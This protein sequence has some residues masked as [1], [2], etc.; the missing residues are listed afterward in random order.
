MLKDEKQN[1]KLLSLV[2][3]W[4]W[5]HQLHYKKWHYW[6]CSSFDMKI[7]FNPIVKPSE[8]GP[9]VEMWFQHTF[10]PHLRPPTSNTFLLEPS[11]TSH[12]SLSPL[13]CLHKQALMPDSLLL[14]KSSLKMKGWF[15]CEVF[16]HSLS[17]CFLFHALYALT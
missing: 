15:L 9:S 14:A 1:I 12:G 2:L 6:A 17:D 5:E 11:Q 3:I 16:L 7:Q 4:P 10:H 8:G 13:C